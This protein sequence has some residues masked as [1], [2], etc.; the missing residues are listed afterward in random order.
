MK[1]L[2]IGGTGAIST[3]FSKACID[4][5]MDLW[6]INRGNRQHRIPKGVN[7]IKANINNIDKSLVKDHIWDSIIDFTIWNENDARRAMQLFTGKTKQFIFL[8][9][10]CIYKPVPL[11]HR[12]MEEDPIENHPVWQ[13]QK[14]KFEARGQ[15]L[16]SGLPLVEV[17]PGHT[18]DVFTIPTNIMGLGYGLVERIKKGKEI[19]VHDD[20]LAKWTI[21]HST[22]VAQGLVGLVGNP[23]TIGECFHITHEK[24]GN[25]LDILNA[26][27]DILN[28]KPN[29]IHI[30]SVRICHIDYET[31]ISLLA[32][33][34]FHKIFDNS[35]IKKFVFSYNPKIDYRDGIKMSVDWHEDNKDK[36]FY[37]KEADALVD[38]I[39]K[40]YKKESING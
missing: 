9:S 8:N 32:H 3:S 29:F 5:G 26:Y 17:R 10:T 21:T 1:V 36:I 4:N 19:I 18:Y 7:F 35:K 13:Y 24:A 23:K 27:G 28:K 2:I 20:G 34:A 31:G 22:D 11:G 40:I 6:M 30:P 14:N 33:R 12:I 25:W 38:K 15:L 39:I 16:R 37:R